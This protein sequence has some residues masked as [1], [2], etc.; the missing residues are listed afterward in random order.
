MLTVDY[1]S[2]V[3]FSHYSVAVVIGGKQ[4]SENSGTCEVKKSAKEA[5]IV[6]GYRTIFVLNCSSK[7][8]RKT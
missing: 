4:V 7:L 8:P 5:S 1:D 2:L 6:R 3:K